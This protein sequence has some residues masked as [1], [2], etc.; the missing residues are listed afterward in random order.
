MIWQDGKPQ[1]E[2]RM[3]D[4]AEASDD[5][6]YAEP[7]M[8]PQ[9]RTQEILFARLVELGGSVAFGREL[10]TITQDPDGVTAHFA[11]GSPSARGTSSAPT[12][13]AR[14]CGARSG[15]P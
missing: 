8:V 1:G 6:P 12:A 15:S 10:L 13:A 4:P 11:A 7:W 2:H 3:F 5:S 14:P 9:W